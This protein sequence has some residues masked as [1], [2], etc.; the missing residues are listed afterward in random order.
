MNKIKTIKNH[1]EAEGDVI[2][3]GVHYRGTDYI[4][5]LQK[6]YNREVDVSIQ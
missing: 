5:H 4:R 3:V 1:F 6:M 2:F